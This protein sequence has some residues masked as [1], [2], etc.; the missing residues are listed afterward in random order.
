MLSNAA[1]FTANG[2]VRLLAERQSIEQQDW[3]LF[4]IEDTGIGIEQEKLQ[5]IFDSFTQADASTTRKYGGTGLGLSITRQLAELMGGTIEVNSI[6]N[7][8]SIFT[9]KLPAHLD[10]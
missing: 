6:V 5:H 3:L 7:H 10:N 2:E 9:V 4:R 1:K 8:G